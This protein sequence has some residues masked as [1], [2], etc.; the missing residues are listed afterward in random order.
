MKTEKSQWAHHRRHTTTSFNEKNNVLVWQ[1]T[2]RQTKEMLEYLVEK[3]P[4]DASRSEFVVGD[5]R[6]DSLKLTLHVLCSA[7][8]GVKLPF[9]P[10]PGAT[11]KD[12][13]EL[14][15]DSQSPPSGYHFT[16]RSVMEYSS[17]HPMSALIANRV[18]PKWI[19]R[20]LLP[21]YDAE[22]KAYH[23]LGRYLRALVSAAGV[24]KAHALHN[25]LEGIV[26]TGQIKDGNDHDS[27]GPAISQNG[28]L[29]EAEILGNL[30]IFTVA[31][32]ETTATTF[33]YAMTLLALHQDIQSWLWEDI[34]EATEHE[35]Q[36]PVE[37]DYNRVFSKMIGPLCV[38][39]WMIFCNSVV[40]PAALIHRYPS[41]RN[42]P[43]VSSSGDYSEAGCQLH[44]HFHIQKRK[45]LSATP[46]IR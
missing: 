1:E 43:A 6:E 12:V 2:I 17:L 34:R 16:F 37:W 25:L 24:K 35:P 10:A 46:D 8:F 15:R 41:A 11:A 22:F 30:Y 36:D 18:I 3:G 27:T 9:K 44:C 42:T 39:V 29:S 19:P 40:F 14:F 23:D 4:C 13:E 32:H 38:M 45:I 33:R 31:G 7:G 20:A 26:G 21:F 5:V 28:G